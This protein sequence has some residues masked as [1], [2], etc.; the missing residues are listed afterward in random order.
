MD[1]SELARLKA[2]YPHRYKTPQIDPSVFLAEGTRVFGDV[3]IGKDSGL[4]FNVVVRGDVNYIRIGEGTNIQDLSM[5]HV[6]WE[7]APCIV[8]NYVTVGHSVVLHA[9]TVGD[10][11]LIGMGST[12]LDG[13]V[14]GDHVL[15]GAGSLVTGNTK[16]P[17]GMKAFGRPAK[18]VGPI[19]DE[20]RKFLAWSAGNYI[21]VA[22]TYRSRQT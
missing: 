19:S 10:Y 11:S 3:V 4:W 1:P 15:L 14:I 21:D 22:K 2:K 5:V 17:S 18:V 20:E 16:I 8:G 12:V 6:S 9:C 7:N 13:A